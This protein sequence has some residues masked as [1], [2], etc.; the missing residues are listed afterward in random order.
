MNLE[1]V[2]RLGTDISNLKHGLTDESSQ[3]KS[4]LGSPTTTYQTTE[5]LQSFEKDLVELDILAKDIED[6]T[7][8]IS[9]F[10]GKINALFES[11]FKRIEGK[12]KALR[13]SIQERLK[14]ETKKVFVLAPLEL[15]RLDRLN[16]RGLEKVKLSEKFKNADTIDL[17]SPN[18]RVIPEIQKFL[19]KWKNLGELAKALNQPS[20]DISGFVRCINGTLNG[21]QE[22]HLIEQDLRKIRTTRSSLS[23]D[24][25]DKKLEFDSLEEID[26][27]FD[28]AHSNLEK[29]MEL[30][31]H[32]APISKD[33]DVKAGEDKPKDE[34]EDLDWDTEFENDPLFVKLQ[35]CGKTGSVQLRKFAQKDASVGSQL[36][37]M[38]VDFSEPEPENTPD[39]N[40]NEDDGFDTKADVEFT[41]K[42][43][44]SSKKVQFTGVSIEVEDELGGKD[45]PDH[46]DSDSDSLKL[47]RIKSEVNLVLSRAAQEVAGRNRSRSGS[48]ESIGSTTSNS[49][50]TSA[51]STPTGERDY[52]LGFE[53]IKLVCTVSEPVAGRH[54]SKN[55]KTFS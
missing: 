5:I 38:G 8:L 30:Q 32:T 18:A 50:Q 25:L 44:S 27:A 48:R 43:S 34:E 7:S 41:L 36:L 4:L 21:L 23:Q 28:V 35:N 39:Q 17:T 19:T 29:E 2:T 15:A 47:Y 51:P 26:D 40:A 6:L 53:P 55:Y 52:L 9:R 37:T 31:S 10:D 46:S 45:F 22:Y 16:I 33:E 13:K 54:Y 3:R 11:E 1:N 12:F 49:S 24:A 42:A 14:L 20:D